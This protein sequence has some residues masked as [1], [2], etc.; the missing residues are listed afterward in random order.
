MSK[1]NR[2]DD[3]EQCIELIIKNQEA[4][5]AADLLL[6]GILENI[7]ERIEALELSVKFNAPLQ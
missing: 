6:T 7:V 1:P 2:I 4:D 5:A 3:L